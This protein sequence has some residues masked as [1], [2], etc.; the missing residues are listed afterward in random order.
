VQWFITHPDLR[1]KLAPAGS[2]RQ[3]AVRRALAVVRARL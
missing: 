3:Q 1:Q 2:Q